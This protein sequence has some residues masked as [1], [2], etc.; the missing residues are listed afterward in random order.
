MKNDVQ[1]YTMSG[2]KVPI[3]FCLELCKVMT[4]FQNS[5]PGELND[6]FLLVQQL[7]I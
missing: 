1:N 7:N 6:K 4:D 2:N 5:F 3:Y